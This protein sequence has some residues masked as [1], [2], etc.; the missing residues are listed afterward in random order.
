MTYGEGIIRLPDFLPTIEIDSGFIFLT[1]KQGH[2]LSISAT[3]ERLVDMLD[4]ME[5]DCDL[6]P[7]LAA[8]E[9]HCSARGWI[10]TRDRSGDQ[11]HWAESADDDRED[12]DEREPDQDDEYSLG[13]SDQGSQEALHGCD[14]LEDDEREPDQDAEY[15]TGWTNQGSQEALHA[16]DEIEDDEREFDDADFDASGFIWGGNEAAEARP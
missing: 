4:A 6:E 3:I 14:E 9:N 12:D 2:R 15:S 13:W 1:C 16:S 8:P 11:T 7:T 5:P 10:E